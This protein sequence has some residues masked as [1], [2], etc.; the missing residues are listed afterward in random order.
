MANVRPKRSR[1]RPSDKLIEFEKLIVLQTLL[2][3]SGIYQ[4]KLH[5]K[6]FKMIGT[7][8]DCSRKVGKRM[9]GGVPRL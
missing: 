6:L 4:H 2:T 5:S 3:T 1:H 7:W 8:K 9:G